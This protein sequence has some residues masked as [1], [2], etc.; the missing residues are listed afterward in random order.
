MVVPDFETALAEVGDGVVAKVPGENRRVLAETA[1]EG[2]VAA[3]TGEVIV[4]IETGKGI[5][6]QLAFDIVGVVIANQHLVGELAGLIEKFEELDAVD[7]IG[8]LATEGI[9]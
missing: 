4:S 3:R 2:V 1:V 5:I 7:G 9:S 6:P 8:S